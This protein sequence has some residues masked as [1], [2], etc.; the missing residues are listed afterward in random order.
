MGN[1]YAALPVGGSTVNVS[2]HFTGK[3]T[4]R[5]QTLGKSLSCNV[6]EAFSSNDGL[7]SYCGGL[8]IEFRYEVRQ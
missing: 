7:I 1:Y 2:Y 6:E 4:R 5:P 8:F 3:S